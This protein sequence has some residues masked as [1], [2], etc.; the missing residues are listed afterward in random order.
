MLIWLEVVVVPPPPGPPGPP[1]PLGPLVADGGSPLIG[2]PS[3]DNP[4]N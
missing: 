4:I 3:S 1:M 2:T